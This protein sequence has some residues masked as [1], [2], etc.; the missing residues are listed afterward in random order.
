VADHVRRAEPIDPGAPT[1]VPGDLERQRRAHQ[2]AEGVE[3]VG[4]TWDQ[5][6]Q[7][8]ARVGLDVGELTLRP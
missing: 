4:G 6:L 7:A 5:L 8:A 2:L 1:A 3:I